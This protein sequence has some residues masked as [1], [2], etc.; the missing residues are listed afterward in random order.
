MIVGSGYLGDVLVRF[1]LMTLW[2]FFLLSN[3]PLQ[4]GMKRERD[5]EEE[6]ESLTK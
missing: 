6:E 5:G 2:V 3:F 1:P 4:V